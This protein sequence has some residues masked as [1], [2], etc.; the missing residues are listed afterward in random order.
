MATS[1]Q[2]KVFSINI[3]SEFHRIQIGTSKRTE[4]FK[5]SISK[6]LGLFIHLQ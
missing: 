5:L 3:Q 6:Y 4:E 2:A 1:H